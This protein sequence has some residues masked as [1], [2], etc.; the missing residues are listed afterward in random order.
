[1]WVLEPYNPSG[2]QMIGKM[3]IWLVVGILLALLLFV[4][5]SALGMDFFQEETGIF[6]S[7]LLVLLACMVTVIAATVTAGIYNLIF[8][9]DYYDFGKMFGFILIAQ[10]II[11]VL[12]VPIYFLFS[13]DI[14]SLLLIVALHISFW[15]LMS[16]FLIESLNSPNYSPSHSIGVVIGY[17]LTLII[18]LMMYKNG[19]ETP[20]YQIYIS[21]LLPS[22]IGYT[23]MPLCHSIRS[24][25]Y[26]GIYSAGANPLYIPHPQDVSVSTTESD[27]VNI[28]L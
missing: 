2:G 27:E 7:L 20:S 14:S 13:A 28:T 1:M 21:L 26:Y 11:F 24:K 6:L 16:Q 23:L 12:M 3:F 9:S 4:I 5:V 18:Y 17:M 22:I 10:S 25:L 15:W 19:N 8:S